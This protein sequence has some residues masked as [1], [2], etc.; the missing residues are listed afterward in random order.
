[1]TEDEAR[2]ALRTY[3]GIGGIEPWIAA[4]HWQATP[5]SWTVPATLEGWMFRL[6]PVAG[7]IWIIMS[8][9]GNQPATWF[10]PAV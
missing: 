6:A 9:T 2:A 1:M 8:V 7:G 4:Q 10:V 5:G 3:D